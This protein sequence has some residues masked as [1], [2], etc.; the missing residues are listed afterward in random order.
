MIESQNVTMPILVPCWGDFVLHLFFGALDPYLD[1]ISR[2]IQSMY[3]QYSR[4]YLH[5]LESI[6]MPS[7]VNNTDNERHH[8][9]ECKGIRLILIQK[10]ILFRSASNQSQEGRL[11]VA[12]WSLVSCR[13]LLNSKTRDGSPKW[14]CK[15]C[16]GC[17]Y[18]EP[19]VKILFYFKKFPQCDEPF[20]IQLATKWL[21]ASSH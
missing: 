16:L 10:L 19:L 4:C 20:S 18:F 7:S 14:K 3:G 5:S 17:Q 2:N 1:Q 8:H 11:G 15:L 21:S 12:G 9:R 13:R 6:S